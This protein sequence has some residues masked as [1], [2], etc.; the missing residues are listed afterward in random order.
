V[1]RTLSA[2][3][4][5]DLP[6]ATAVD[7]NFTGANLSGCQVY[8]VSAWNVTLEGAHQRDLIITPPQENAVT[9]DSLQVAQFLYLLLNNRTLRDVIE[10][11]G[12]KAVLI[13]G[14]FAGRPQT[15]PRR[16]SR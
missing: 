10:T 14:R 5:A 4:W 6:L 16:D 13:L 2:P 3:T 15:D 8:G 12:K 7:A 11:V 9:T 1:E